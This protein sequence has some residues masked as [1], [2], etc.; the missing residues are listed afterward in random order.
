M[1][2]GPSNV[3]PVPNRRRSQRVFLRVPIQVIARGPDKQHVSED[4]FTLVVNAHGALFPL[5]LKVDVGQNIILKHRDTEEEQSVRVVRLNP[6]AEGKTEI[7][8]E[9][10]R[11][12][13]KFWRVSFPPEDWAPHAPEITADTF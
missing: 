9:F 7:A 3:D 2:P 13:P 12:A 8:V 11:P 10:L 5:S 4:T 6:V 1:T